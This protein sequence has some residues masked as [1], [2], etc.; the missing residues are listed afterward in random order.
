M[1][2]TLICSQTRAEDILRR[3]DLRNRA[4]TPLRFIFPC[5]EKETNLKN[6]GSENGYGG[7]DTE[8]EQV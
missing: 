2:F 8:K 5:R 4:K 3:K 1:T 7:V 6:F